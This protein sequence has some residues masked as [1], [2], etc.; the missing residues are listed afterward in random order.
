MR[1]RTI[2]GVLAGLTV[3]GVV[4]AM[5]ASLGG[6]TSGRV[7]AD[8][9]AVASC[10]TDGVTTSYASSWDATDRRYE[11]TSVTVSGISN[12]CDGQTLSVSLTDS[13]NAQLGSGSVAIPSDVL[14]TQVTVSLSTA[15]SAEL[16]T[17]VHVAIA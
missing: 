17:G 1:R 15:A 16:T 13:T 8:D 9:A 7:G 3:F 11:V 5:A 12:T 14:V 10:D 6:I 2:A 4:F